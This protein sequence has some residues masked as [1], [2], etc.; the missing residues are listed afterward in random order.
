M[1]FVIPMVYI[2]FVGMFVTAATN[3]LY[4]QVIWD[5]VELVLTWNSPLL[6]IFSF[7]MVAMATIT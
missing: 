5:P 2:T 3:I 7:I 1:G 6:S 4:G